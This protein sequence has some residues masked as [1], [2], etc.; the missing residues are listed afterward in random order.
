[1][2]FNHNT[3]FKIDCLLDFLVV[4]KDPLSLMRLEGFLFY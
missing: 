4:R 1:M 3:M 2:N